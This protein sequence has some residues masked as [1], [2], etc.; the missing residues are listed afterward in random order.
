MGFHCL[1]TCDCIHPYLITELLSCTVTEHPSASL[2][3]C[4]R[5]KSVNSAF[6]CCVSLDEKSSNNFPLDEKVPDWLSNRVLR[7]TAPLTEAEV[8]HAIHSLCSCEGRT[9]PGSWED[10]H[11]CPSNCT[12][13][14]K[15]QHLPPP[16]SEL[17]CALGSNITIF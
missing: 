16:G 1:R 6:Q 7:A 14:L 10:S 15:Q 8:A 17:L 13:A 3:N 12:P 2:T 5:K 4:P 9:E 11:P